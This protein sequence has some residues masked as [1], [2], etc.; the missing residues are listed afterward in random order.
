MREKDGVSE[1]RPAGI[2][3]NYENGIVGYWKADDDNELYT[4]LPV[5]R[6]IINNRLQELKKSASTKLEPQEL[7][8]I[9]ISQFAAVPVANGGPG[10]LFVV[11]KGLSQSMS[12][13]K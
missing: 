4:T 2:K 3:S 5:G 1:W 7:I 8:L 9:K 10:K 11:I 12:K 13:S 6:D